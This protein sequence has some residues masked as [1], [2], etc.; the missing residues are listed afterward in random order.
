[1]DEASK[2]VGAQ[3][4]PPSLGTDSGP[5]PF[6]GPRL[7]KL[8]EA[9]ERSFRGPEAQGTHIPSLGKPP[10]GDI[11]ARGSGSVTPEAPSGPSTEESLT[12]FLSRGFHACDGVGRRDRPSLR[13]RV[14][15]TRTC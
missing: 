1:V 11:V 6:S 5:S 2:V 4:A 9:R 12:L 15:V 7:G 14:S 3:S 8:P 10:G 13:E